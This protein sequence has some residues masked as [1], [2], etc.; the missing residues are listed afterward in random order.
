M[1]RWGAPRLIG[2]YSDA[3]EFAGIL[4]GFFFSISGGLL[5]FLDDASTPT[6]A[7]SIRVGVISD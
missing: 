3:S 6:S 2:C 1:F 7:D 5:E 4:P